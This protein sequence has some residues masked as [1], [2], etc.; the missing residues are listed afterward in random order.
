MARRPAYHPISAAAIQPLAAPP[1]LLG[2]GALDH[3]M[4][5]RAGLWRSSCRL[6]TV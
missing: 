3:R 5:L 6:G 2:V 4:G 1:C